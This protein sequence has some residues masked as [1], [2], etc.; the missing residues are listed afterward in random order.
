MGLVIMN[1]ATFLII[2]FFS[3]FRSA[4]GNCRNIRCYMKETSSLT[5]PNVLGW[6]YSTCAFMLQCSRAHGRVPS[7]C[8]NGDKKMEACTKKCSSAYEC[9]EIMYLTGKADCKGNTYDPN[10][11]MVPE[12][13][14]CMK[15]DLYTDG[16]VEILP[17]EVCLNDDDQVIICP[18]M[19]PLQ[20]IKSECHSV[21]GYHNKISISS[22]IIQTTGEESC[23]KCVEKATAKNCGCIPWIFCIY[24][25]YDPF[26]A[27][28]GGQSM[29][30][31]DAQEKL[32]CTQ[33]NLPESKSI[34]K[35]AMC[36]VAC[37]LFE[38]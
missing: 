9:Q 7:R 36:A 11:W 18:N 4:S 1:F 12:K 34:C 13:T 15:H 17:D 22:N 27:C 5:S 19:C 16:K 30:L 24:A 28:D 29:S 26:I 2:L 3:F 38:N 37:L 31:E 35:D 25:F 14:C 32:N 8:R 20:I 33:N 6:E 23:K 21:C 10:Q